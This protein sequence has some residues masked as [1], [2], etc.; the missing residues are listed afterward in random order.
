MQ[1]AVNF[2]QIFL[3]T[4][5]S[6]DSL[7][8]TAAQVGA[9]IRRRR[10]SQENLYNLAYTF[11]TRR[12][13]LSWRATCV[14]SNSQQLASGLDFACISPAHSVKNIALLFVFTGQ[15]AQW[16]QMGNELLKLSKTFRE[17]ME[18]S[19]RVL[20]SIGASWSILSELLR[21]ESTSRVD[22]SE[23]AQPLTT[24]IQIAL[25]DL[26]SD[27][28]IKPKA[29]IGHSS[30]EI[31]AAYAAG[32]ISQEAALRIAYARGSL[33]GLSAKRL[34]KKGAMLAVGLGEAEVSSYLSSLK[35]GVACVA[36][37]NSPKSTTVSG[38]ESAIVEL[39]ELFRA[40]GIFARKVKVDTAYHSHHMLGVTD[41]YLHSMRR[42]TASS[43]KSEALFVSTVTGQLKEDDFGVEYWVKNLVSQ[44]RFSEGLRTLW[45]AERNVPASTNKKLVLLELGPHSILASAIQQTLSEEDTKSITYAYVPTLIRRQ[46]A[47][48]TVFKSLAKLA[49]LGYPVD[50]EQVNASV[51]HETKVAV[52]MDLEPYPW[53][54]STAYWH[55]SRLSREFRFRHH[56]QH[57]LL[58]SRIISST[59]F[60]P[61]WRNLLSIGNLPWL[62]EHVIDNAVVYPGS[63]YVCMA[64]E[65]GRQI[66][67]D[68]QA[69]RTLKRYRFKNIDFT[70]AL[71]IPEEPKK[72][73]IQLVLKL[74]S[75]SAAEEI[76][77]HSWSSFSIYAMTNGVWHKHC[78]GLLMIEGEVENE[79]I[80]SH[81]KEQGRELQ[82]YDIFKK[83]SARVS[84]MQL[85]SAA[86]L[87]K[88][89]SMTGN[90]YERNFMA[91]REL[92]I[93]ERQLTA[94]LKV[95]DV[96]KSMPANYMSNY[97]IHPATM[98][99]MF[100][101]VIP[102]CAR[103]NKQGSVMINFLGDLSI[104]AKVAH[105]PGQILEL[106]TSIQRNEGRA[107]SIQIVAFQE[108]EYDCS[109]V[110]ELING[111]V[112]EMR[113]SNGFGTQ[114]ESLK[115]P[116]YQLEWLPDV[117][118]ATANTIRQRVHN[119]PAL[120]E[121]S[122]QRS[123]VLKEATSVYVR[124]C[125]QEIEE[126][127]LQ[128]PN[129]HRSK[130]VQWMHNFSHTQ[131][132]QDSISRM[133]D[134]AAEQRCLDQ[135]RGAGIEGE[136]I[137]RIGCHIGAILTAQ[138]D[139]LTLLFQDDLLY[140]FYSDDLS[141][142]APDIAAEYFRLLTFK[143]PSASILEI[144]AGTGGTT[145]PLLKAAKRNGRLCIGR[146]HFTDISPAFMEKAKG[147]F[148]SHASCMDFK[149]LDIEKD[150]EMQGF[151]AESY[152]C[153]V[154]SNV[155]HATRIINNTLQNVYKLLKPGG[156][157][158]LIEMTH[159][160]DSYFLS[161]GVLP[162][163]WL[164]KQDRAVYTS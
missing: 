138:I 148:Q 86:T 140:R 149:P 126:A 18:T 49:E 161:F 40:V 28:Q 67:E 159:N 47:C 13:L 103:Q 157:L 76:E 105:V 131:F 2:P 101:S 11:A 57:D 82:V 97:A 132:C 122:S 114:E 63:A 50:L 3:I 91:L 73:E 78:T 163:W 72:V 41:D 130:L 62:R 43:P 143:N 125:L 53:D 9:W 109:A 90:S 137:T 100:Q 27:L 89:W 135:A 124:R 29:V 8:S 133:A 110:F 12:S 102:L 52:I 75:S 74:A 160:I 34:A 123:R 139:P 79:S 24:A 115:K 127:P 42:I 136:I 158:I 116:L 96:A 14:A 151:K 84:T 106:A 88:H 164:G 107:D 5:N 108:Q 31:A 55:E 64:L 19:D 38:D 81:S 145:L 87:Y 46:D 10:P 56:G 99:G 69:G 146:Y 85:L 7:L 111:E 121:L 39:E 54:H 144:G 104:S 25:V 154:A 120:E 129:D 4:A 1:V 61:V 83:I 16:P 65:A 98:D 119:D 58:G 117:N 71:V 70:R 147:L 51:R 59:P 21:D 32:A 44:V 152:D 80:T 118:F 77:A 142:R 15:G 141:K 48:Q 150:P 33:S 153:I 26:L 45:E 93:G 95:P 30:G 156:K 112:F 162:G 155:L 35:R 92:Q 68:Q 20:K 113:S 36:C 128:I 6:K 37:T 17:S 134:P 66:Y 94:R 22:E 60:E 23:I